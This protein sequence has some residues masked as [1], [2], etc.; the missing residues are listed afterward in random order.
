MWERVRRRTESVVNYWFGDVKLDEIQ[1][2]V[3]GHLKAEENRPG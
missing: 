2:L 1:P 3:R